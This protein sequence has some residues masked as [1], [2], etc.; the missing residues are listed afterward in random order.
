M[1]NKEL[2]PPWT[3]V[4]AETT[5]YEV[6]VD[7]WGRSY[8]FSHAMLPTSIVSADEE[9]LSSPIRLAGI[10]NGETVTWQS[11][12]VFLLC[13]NKS[14]AVVSG[15]QANDNLIIDVTSTV[16]FDGMIRMD[17]VIMPQRERSS[18]REASPQI[19]RLWL[20]VP[21][22]K[23]RATLFHY[24]PGGWGHAKNSGAIPENGLTLP[25]KPFIWIGWE[26]GGLSWFAESD[27]GWEPKEENYC[28][29]I[30]REGE[31]VILRLHLL[32]KQPRK[33]PL[34]LTMGL[35]ATPVKPMPKD[36][37]QWRIYHGANYGI[38][39]QAINQEEDETVL[40]HITELGV[41]TLVSY[42]NWTPIQGYWKTTEESK[43]RHLVSECHKRG[44][45][46]LLYFGYE[47]STLAPEWGKMADDVLVKG[48][49]GEFAGGYQR[50][51]EQRA[52]IVCYNSRWQDYFIEGISRALEDYGFDGVYLDGTIEPWGCANE[53]HG[54]GYRTLDGSLKATYPIFAVREL[55]KRLYTI[56]QSKGGIVNAHQS[57]CC[58]TPTLAFCHSYW[59]G[60]QF[61]GGELA[62][63]A[64][65]K[66][67]LD[68]FR[69][70]FMGKNFGI[71]CEFLV[72][73]KPPDWTFERALAFTLLHDVLVRPLNLEEL[74]LMSKIWKVMTDFGVSTAEWYPYWENERFLKLEPDY[75]KASFY[76]KKDK[77]LLVVSNLSDKQEVEGKVILDTTALKISGN[78]RLCYDAIT[79][80]NIPI[81]DSGVQISLQPMAARLIQIE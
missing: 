36:F 56:I 79:G 39:N 22:N 2:L 48:V 33:L 77:L 65:Q 46:V 10:V 27:K 78:L 76:Q 81:K 53:R 38:E 43:L 30:V 51:P 21:F 41:K 35:Q 40:D 23:H 32:D 59:D 71:P 74:E 14:E 60:E 37:H 18:K 26:E 61:Q 80:E 49:N 12:D 66:L 24:W 72:Y 45:K 8:R 47:L 20:E 63:E 57:T 44:I 11:K 9:I 70:E 67:P 64:L 69:A 19:E 29:E 73:E 17:M 50:L 28:I 6:E 68:T 5:D 16:E 52:Y 25:F 54:C 58:V 15:C 75:I 34:T 1:D 55:M 62:T 31:E 3:E 42:E 13:S 4:K 7:M